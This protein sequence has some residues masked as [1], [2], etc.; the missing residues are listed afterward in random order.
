MQIGNVVEQA[1]DYDYKIILTWGE[2]PTDLD[3]HL[4]TPE[5][6]GSAYH[7][8]FADRGSAAGPPYAWLDVDDVSSWGPEAT[9]I[10]VLH[11][12]TYT[13]AVYDWSG[14]GLL[15]TSGAHI[16][17]FTGRDRVGGYDVPSAGEDGSHWWWT[18]GTVD[19]ATGSFTLVN[20]L[21]PE[22]PVGVPISMGDMP[23]K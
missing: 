14:N 4:F 12:G 5:I 15:S 22:I 6:E 17:V 1:S 13:F 23:L 21:T 20:T 16:E 8:Y 10:E 7:V 9:T 18:L 11:P 2:Y 19:G 3:S